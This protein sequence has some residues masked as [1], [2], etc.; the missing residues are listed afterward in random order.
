MGHNP[1]Y[2]MG[3]RVS[4]VES[5]ATL[6]YTYKT[7]SSTYETMPYAY[8]TVPYAGMHGCTLAGLHAA[9]LALAIFS[10]PVELCRN[11]YVHATGAINY[12]MIA[13]ACYI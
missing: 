3:Q 13:I 2:S 12:S 1:D 10:R 11:T 9:T 6:I 7:A 8:G 4:E 5:V